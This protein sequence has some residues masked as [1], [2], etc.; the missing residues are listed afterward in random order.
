MN[1]AAQ[2]I[3]VVAVI[4]AK[5]DHPMQGKW[6]PHWSGNAVVLVSVKQ[7]Q[8]KHREELVA[9]EQLTISTQ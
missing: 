2:N 4:F 1:L 7:Q 6:H 3:V 8:G 9:G 5:Y